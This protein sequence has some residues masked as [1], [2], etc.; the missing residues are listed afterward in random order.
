M[1]E[2][3]APR[4]TLAVVFRFDMTFRLLNYIYKQQ[5]ATIVAACFVTNED[6][7]QCSVTGILGAVKQKLRACQGVA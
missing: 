5:P 4:M 7:L 6:S 2:V 3:I 1:F